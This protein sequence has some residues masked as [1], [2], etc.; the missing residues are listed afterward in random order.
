M[1]FDDGASYRGGQIRL[2]EFVAPKSSPSW[3]TTFMATWMPP[4]PPTQMDR[5][6]GQATQ[7]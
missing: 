5:S 4:H 6:P 3:V 1:L 7:V 2:K